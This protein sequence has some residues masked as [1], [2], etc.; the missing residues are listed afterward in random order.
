MRPTRRLFSRAPQA[1]EFES[2]F[3]IQGQSHDHAR[4]RG[5]ALSYLRFRSREGC[6]L[7]FWRQIKKLPQQG[8]TEVEHYHQYDYSKTVLVNYGTVFKTR[9]EVYDVIAGYG[10]WLK[11]Q[12]WLFDTHNSDIGETLDWRY[13]AKEYLFWSLGKWQNGDYITLSPSASTLQFKPATGVVQSLKNIINGSYSA[14]NKEGFGLDAEQMNVV[15]D[16]D[17]VTIS[18]KQGI[19]IY[20][21]RLFI[22]ETEHAITLNNKT[23]FSLFK[24]K[25]N[26]ATC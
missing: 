26:C 10:E 2:G 14:L 20:G 25:N 21:L 11:T 23:M 8:G 6:D 9:Q 22:K 19:G 4:R 7:K 3:S 5:P 12:G 1:C 16:D 15:R 13:S 18:H 17:I 24:K